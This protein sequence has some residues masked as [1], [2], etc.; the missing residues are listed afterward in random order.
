MQSMAITGTASFS[1]GSLLSPAVVVPNEQFDLAGNLRLN[2]ST[3]PAVERIQ[4]L[5]QH[6]KTTHSQSTG[7][8]MSPRSLVYFPI[9]LVIFCF[10]PQCDCYHGHIKICKYNP[11]AFYWQYIPGPYPKEIHTDI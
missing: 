10:L 9:G 5:R 6:D 2:T 11:D 4:V 8:F 3:L 7:T 1:V